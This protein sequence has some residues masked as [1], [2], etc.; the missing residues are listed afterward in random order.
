MDAVMTEAVIAM[1]M[2][3]RVC[4]F[5][6]APYVESSRITLFGIGILVVRNRNFVT[7]LGRE[8]ARYHVYVLVE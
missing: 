7:I 1:H 5:I 6:L 3:L 8:L 4:F 2:L